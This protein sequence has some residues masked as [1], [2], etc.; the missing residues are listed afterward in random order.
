MI[1]QARGGRL[2]VGRCDGHRNKATFV[3]GTS[4]LLEFSVAF[5]PD[6][7]TLASGR[8]R[9][10]KRSFC[11]TWLR[12][13]KRPPFWDTHARCEPRWRTVRTARHWPRGAVDETIKLWD[14]AACR[15]GKGHPQRTTRTATTSVA[16]SPDGKALASAGGHDDKTM[17]LWDVETGKELV[18]L[19]GHIG[20]VHCVA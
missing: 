2:A 6:G 10:S 7:K 19:K 9:R 5:S 20:W 3:E 1:L 17:K 15:S 16:Y 14:V 8:S 13:R 4:V 18:T 11:G 12:A